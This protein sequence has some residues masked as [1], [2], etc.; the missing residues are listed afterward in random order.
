M[1]QELIRQLF[2][3]ARN[4]D[5]LEAFERVA[6]EILSASIAADSAGA[7]EHMQFEAWH[8]QHVS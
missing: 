5:S 8:V 3:T 2:H 1:T 4:A 7:N 6:S